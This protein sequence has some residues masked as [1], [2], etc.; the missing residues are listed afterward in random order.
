MSRHDRFNGFTD[1]SFV[2]A[3][4]ARCFA[5]GA[6][7]LAFLDGGEI[8][9]AAEL[10]DCRT[11]SHEAAE[12]AFSVDDAFQGRGIGTMLFGRLIECARLLGCRTLHVTTHADN[13]AMKTLARRFGARLCFQS[14]DAVGVIDLGGGLPAEAAALVESLRQSGPAEVAHLSVER[15]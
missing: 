11:G 7:V 12:I 15:G 1:D 8:R 4:A 10:H 13:G 3:Y 5:G 14:V 2:T 6:T 9:G